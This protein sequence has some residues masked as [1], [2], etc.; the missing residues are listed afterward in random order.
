MDMITQVVPMEE[1]E[2]EVVEGVATTTSNLM[3]TT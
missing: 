1:V 2:E 3:V